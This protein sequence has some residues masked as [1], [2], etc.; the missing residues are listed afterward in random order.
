MKIQTSPFFYLVLVI[1]CHRQDLRF[2]LQIPPTSCAGIT[3]WF[4]VLPS[5]HRTV[6]VTFLIFRSFHLVIFSRQT[7]FVK[8]SPAPLYSS[9]W[10]RVW[11]HHGGKH[12]CHF[13]SQ[14]NQEQMCPAPIYPLGGGVAIFQ[15][16]NCANRVGG[17]KRQRRTWNCAI[18]RLQ[19]FIYFSFRSTKSIFLADYCSSETCFSGALMFY[20]LV[21]DD[22][23]K[24]PLYNWQCWKYQ[25]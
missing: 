4:H 14:Y 16:F 10:I 18:I 25:G 17:S 7:G 24:E 15:R 9:N 6:Y 3:S 5:H 21:I 8:S 23:S 20:F 2:Q 19:W 1:L 13:I 12:I 22:F 11:L